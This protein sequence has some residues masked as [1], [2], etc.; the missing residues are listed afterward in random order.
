MIRIL[1]LTIFV[2]GCGE[3]EQKT[4]K[5][6]QVE[7]VDDKDDAES[8][9]NDSEQVSEEKGSETIAKEENAPDW[10]KE[11]PVQDPTGLWGAFD[12]DFLVWLRFEQN[13]TFEGYWGQVS[14]LG[15]VFWR[16]VAGIYVLDSSAMTLTFEVDGC[17][18]HAP[19]L[20]PKE[21]F[22]ILIVRD[23]PEPWLDLDGM[24]LDKQEKMINPTIDLESQQQG[25]LL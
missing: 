14:S 21:R 11:S 23:Q 16:A 25:C 15:D 18:E 8:E 13:Y 24:K 19:H 17:M 6:D 5:S 9:N 22:Y 4:A 1:L 10:R 20:Y 2:I 7:H 12:G 3:D